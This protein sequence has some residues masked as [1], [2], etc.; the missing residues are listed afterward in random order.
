MDVNKQIA[1]DNETALNI[2]VMLSQARENLGLSSEALATELNLSESI[3]TGIED[4][5]F[6]QDIPVAFIRGYVKSYATKVGLDTKTILGEFDSQTGSSEPSLQKVQTISKFGASR[7][8]LNSNSYLIKGTSF[9]L[10]LL[11]LSF[12]GWKVWNQYIVPANSADS[13]DSAEGG[14][15]AEL[16]IVDSEL[17]SGT[18]LELGSQSD[19]GNELSPVENQPTAV[20]T[21]GAAD[22]RQTGQGSELQ[23]SELQTAVDSGA[24]QLEADDEMAAVAE[25][26]SLAQS[27]TSSEQSAADLSTANKSLVLQDIVM[28]FTADCWVRVVD[29]RGEV[30]ALGVKRNGKHM[31]ISGVAPIVVVLGD[32]SAVSLSFAGNAYD[33]SSYRA[34][35]R[36]EIVLN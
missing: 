20:S 14:V 6:E 25:E 4:N 29:A 11:F 9:I 26:A 18:D 33:L 30:I 10:V 21:N 32:P 19:S 31:E 1:E 12:A 13:A 35:R 2:G 28:D 24:A 36:A 8:E 7:K 27:Q 3:I 16:D 23:D 17:D 34:G 22:Q 15:V 5:D